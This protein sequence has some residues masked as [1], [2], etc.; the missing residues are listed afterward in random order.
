MQ[1]SHSGSKQSTHGLTALRSA[2][3]GGDV[4]I[5]N[6]LNVSNIN[7]SPCARTHWH[8]HA[9]SQLLAALTRLNWVCDKEAKPGKIAAGDVVWCP[10]GTTHWHGTDEG[11]YTIHQ[12]VTLESVEWLEEV[13]NE[14]YAK[15]KEWLIY[16]NVKE[17]L[18]RNDRNDVGAA[19]TG[20]T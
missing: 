8:T 20:I 6:G 5:A 2:F 11:S 17:C 14:D 12:T 13:D 1:I 9:G 4:H 16:W 10:A 18:Y 15:R 3:T 7:F 19:C